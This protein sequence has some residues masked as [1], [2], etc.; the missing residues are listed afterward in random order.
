MQVTGLAR[1]WL[2]DCTVC[3]SR[4]QH[5]L[6]QGLYFVAHDGYYEDRASGLVVPLRMVPQSELHVPSSCLS[7]LFMQV[8]L[9]A[10]NLQMRMNEIMLHNAGGTLSTALRTQVMSMLCP[11]PIFALLQK[12][13]L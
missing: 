10:E 7:R 8:S 4:V 6:E 1:Y 13:V 3:C 5:A 2:V 9:L 12:T 11:P